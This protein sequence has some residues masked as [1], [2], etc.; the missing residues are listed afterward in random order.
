MSETVSNIALKKL[1]GLQ[2]DSYFN[3][4]PGTEI[5]T[6]ERDCLTI[7]A[8][9]TNQVRI[10]TNDIVNIVSPTEFE[11]V[12]R[13]DNVINTG[14]IKVQLEILERMLYDILADFGIEDAFFVGAIDDDELGQK[15]ILLLEGTPI[16]NHEIYHHMKNN[17]GR[18][19]PKAI[20]WLPSFVTTPTGKI[21]R[22][23]SLEKYKDL[24][25]Q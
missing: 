22:K 8:P 1:N 13:I 23:A 24:I 2:P 4:F 19:A 10:V 11:W 6:D 15:L 3:V 14:G 16:D 9:V 25:N 18:L 5:G 17:L 21:Q 7:K 12:G 20:Y